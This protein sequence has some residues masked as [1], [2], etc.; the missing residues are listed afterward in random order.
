VPGTARGLTEDEP[1]CG[2]DAERPLSE[3]PRS[4][5]KGFRHV[6]CFSNLLQRVDPSSGPVK[7]SEGQ[8]SSIVR[9]GA[10]AGFEEL[11]GLVFMMSL[12]E[13]GVM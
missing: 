10:P 7:C 9:R 8:L 2:G 1:A 13:G 12:F 4:P 5:L 11:E 3:T 6:Y